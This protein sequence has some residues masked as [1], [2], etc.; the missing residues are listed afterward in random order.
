MMNGHKRVISISVVLQAATVCLALDL[1]VPKGVDLPGSRDVIVTATQTPVRYFADTATDT[2]LRESL[3]GVWRVQLVPREE[4]ALRDY[5]DNEK[6]P[7]WITP[8]ERPKEGREWKPVLM[9]SQLNVG[10]NRYNILHKTL[11][12]S[13]F[14]VPASMKNSEKIALR[15]GGFGGWGRVYVNGK[16]VGYGLAESTPFEVDVTDVVKREGDND[17]LI[18][19]TASW[20]KY[21]GSLLRRHLITQDHWWWSNMGLWKDSWILARPAVRTE[22]VYI[23]TSTRKMELSVATR[24]EN[25]SKSKITVKINSKVLDRNTPVLFLPGQ[26]ADIAPG[27]KTTV[28]QTV[29]W[30][31]ARLWSPADPYLYI[32]ETTIVK[33]GKVIGEN[34]ADEKMDPA[35]PN[36]LKFI[37]NGGRILQLAQ[38]K[39][40]YWLPS[41]A[42]LESY[43][44]SYTFPQAKGNPVFANLTESDLCNWDGGRGETCSMVLSKPEKGAWKNL[45]DVGEMMKLS[46]L[47]EIPDAKGS[48]LLCQYD[49][50]P[51]VG[52]QP[53]PTRLLA[54]LLTYANRPADAPKKV[55]FL[56]SPEQLKRWEE[57]LGLLPDVT[58]W[59]DVDSCAAAV[60]APE[61][62]LSPPRIAKLEALADKGATVLFIADKPES[63]AGL[64]DAPKLEKYI[65]DPRPKERQKEFCRLYLGAS[66]GPMGMVVKT[67]YDVLDGVNNADL[68]WRTFGGWGWLEQDDSAVADYMILCDETWRPVTLPY[69]M[70]EKKAGKGRIVLTTLKDGD[71]KGNWLPNMSRLWGNVFVNLGATLKDSQA[72]KLQKGGFT[73]IGLA[74]FA[75]A[76]LRDDAAGD[77]KGGWAD[78]G[79]N[80]LR[81]FVGG[82]QVLNN[83]PFL[84][85]KAE[86]NKGKVA[87]ALASKHVKI[88]YP[89]KIERIPLGNKRYSRLY[90]LHTSAW[91]SG[92][93]ATYRIKYEKIY[94]IEQDIPIVAGERVMDWWAAGDGKDCKVAW[95][96]PGGEK[97]L[98]G[99]YIT[100]WENPYPKMPLQ[101]LDMI[102]EN[103]G[104]LFLLGI[105]GQ[106]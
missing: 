82:R 100:V 94:E 93:L 69:A 70:A 87:V 32:L 33:D 62:T 5:P 22:S 35:A 67:D 19:V 44:A 49:L 78:Q 76:A 28:D 73:C 9:P 101:F 81:H 2:R 1:T 97:A 42:K 65:P 102:S 48:V 64:T 99:L 84:I 79:G 90:F 53:V 96:G 40:T 8:E 104:A 3:N 61:T 16:D 27:Q 66:S 75:N 4:F 63:V 51:R 39:W 34:G 30:K 80:D 25:D 17:L 77:G 38:S 106:E 23:R 7:L 89:Q 46:V 55:A 13:T 68:C 92:K 86:N 26:Q 29:F 98:V 57:N 14:R 58:D 36:L 95:K 52:T 91:C 47:A 21:C 60:V 41:V 88:P 18:C 72:A 85:P 24:L 11:L 45:A 56:A 37:R 83:V 103:N 105:T 15:F 50:C 6:M 20:T 43:P 71:K 59:A 74:P 31:D 12:K 54:N 10:P